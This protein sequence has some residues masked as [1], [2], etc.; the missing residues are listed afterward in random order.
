MSTTAGL[1]FFPGY[2]SDERRAALDAASLAW[3]QVGRA[4]VRR[5][6]PGSYLP[7][8]LP[9]EA[10]APAPAPANALAT[11]QEAQPPMVVTGAL[12]GKWS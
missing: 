5:L 11:R 8:L 4:E 7:P 12:V 1:K 2:L 9:G 6:K 3:Q 10:G